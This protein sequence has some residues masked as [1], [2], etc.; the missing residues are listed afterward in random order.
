V[1]FLVGV[2]VLYRE[3]QERGELSDEFD[4]RDAV[5][6]FGAIYMMAM[7]QGLGSEL[8]DVD[9]QVGL[10]EGLLELHLKGLGY[11]SRPLGATAGD[12]VYEDEA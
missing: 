9:A 11:A 7:L 12:K 6:V 3:A 5:L 1:G 4:G 10:V 8:F 2:A